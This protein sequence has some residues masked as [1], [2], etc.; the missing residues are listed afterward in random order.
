[1]RVF[2]VPLAMV[3]LL[4]GA[5][6]GLI[7]LIEEIK[8]RF[9]PHLPTQK[10]TW[11]WKRT[12]RK[13][14]AWRF[15]TPLALAVMLLFP[16]KSHA[17]FDLPGGPDPVIDVNAATQWPIQLGHMVSTIEQIIK[18][19]GWL[20]AQLEDMLIQG[21]FEFGIPWNDVTG[22]LLEEM[23]AY[24]SEGLGITYGDN[25]D[26]EWDAVYWLGRVDDNGQWL[27]TWD[28]RVQKQHE[29][30]ATDAIRIDILQKAVD[31]AFGRNQLIRAQNALS[32]E[33]YR[34]QQ[35]ERQTAMTLGNLQAIAF[36][37][38]VQEKFTR[39]AYQHAF[40]SNFDRPPQPVVFHES[41]L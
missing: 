5:C 2:A 37:N 34:Q 10:P 22:P 41:G 11:Q 19:N 27:G 6:I 29:S 8:E 9:F 3:T 24:A 38:E 35:M 30:F 33:K 12:R 20:E 4:S 7:F 15:L 1:M 32:A 23:A 13:R 14:V 17:Q 28:D 31:L 36:A 16:A 25:V 40:M 26:A 18:T 21:A 39:E